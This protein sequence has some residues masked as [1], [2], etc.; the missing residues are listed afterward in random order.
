MGAGRKEQEMC[1][2]RRPG[3]RRYRE[4]LGLSVYA[5]DAMQCLV[6]NYSLDR[7]A[8]GVGGGG[9]TSYYILCIICYVIHAVYYIVYTKYCMLEPYYI[10]HTTYYILHTTY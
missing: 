1:P 8:G 2:W 10:L 7:E 5:S 4:F 9:G 3:H 6:Q